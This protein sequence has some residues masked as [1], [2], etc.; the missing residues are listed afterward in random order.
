MTKFYRGFLLIFALVLL[1][2]MAFLGLRPTKSYAQTN[3]HYVKYAIMVEKDGAINASLIMS[4]DFAGN[5]NAIQRENFRLRLKGILDNEIAEKKAE[6]NGKFNLSGEADYDPNK[7][8]VFGSAVKGE[9]FVGYNIK[10][11]STK[12]FKFYNNIETIYEEGFLYDKSTQI[13]DNPF[14]DSYEDGVNVLTVAQKYKNYYYKASEGLAVEQYVKTNYNPNFY[15]DYAT[16]HARMKSTAQSV[17]QDN[18]NYY[19]HIWVSDAEILTTDYDMVLKFNIIHK[20]WWYVLGTAIPLGVMFIFIA[21]V[22][23]LPKSNKKLKK[24]DNI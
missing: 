19:H 17:I 12:V 8:I 4:T 20:G 22:K 15:V 6:I 14:N 13:L 7:H 2:P 10:Y 18:Q 3:N 23:V 5:F 9:D 11:S 21:V 1:L 24:T 16:L